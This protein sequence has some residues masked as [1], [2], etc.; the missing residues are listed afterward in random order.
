MSETVPGTNE[1]LAHLVGKAREAYLHEPT[2]R[3]FLSSVEKVAT[4]EAGEAIRAWWT[5]CPP[6]SDRP[7]TD[8]LTWLARLKPWQ[9]PPR[10][11]LEVL[12]PEWPPDATAIIRKAAEANAKLSIDIS[13]IAF[14]RRR[15]ANDRYGM[16]WAAYV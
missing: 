8:L 16:F 1:V 6:T 3:N 9:P 11:S 4:H 5:E 15:V 12:P 10:G 7:M 2:L 13:D 14:E